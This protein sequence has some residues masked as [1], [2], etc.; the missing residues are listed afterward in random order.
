MKKIISAA[1]AAVTMFSVSAVFAPAYGVEPTQPFFSIKSGTYS[2]PQVVA[3]N[4]DEEFDVYYTTD[5][6]KPTAK[7][8]LYE[9][10]PLI[11]RTNTVVRTASYYEGELIERDKLTIYIKTPEP[12]ASVQGGEYSESFSVE[13]TCPDEEAIIYY[14]VDGSVPTQESK[15]YKKAINIKEST[16]LRF[17]AFGKDKKRSSAVTEKYEINSDVYSDSRRQKLFELINETR[18]EY[19]LSPLE[20][21]PLLSDIAQQRARETSTYFS[22]WRTNGTK[23]DSLLAANG[24]KRNVRGENLAYYYPTANQTLRSWMSDSGHKANVLNPDAKYVGIGCY[25]NGY[26]YYWSEI[27]IGE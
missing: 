2:A 26:T 1:I 21:L 20:E 27:F 8:K 6:S 5:G 12:A 14:T 23:W 19:G 11:I 15:K 22:H 16:T 25:Y 13:L 7:D 3:I 9:G 17:T 18:A 10:F 4:H 24:L